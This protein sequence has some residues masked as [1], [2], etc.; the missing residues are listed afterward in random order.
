LRASGLS[1]KFTDI[2]KESECDD[3]P[4]S[5]SE[6]IQ[7]LKQSEKLFCQLN[8]ISHYDSPRKLQDE[9]SCS[10]LKEKVE[11]QN[12]IRQVSVDLQKFKLGMMKTARGTAQVQ[13]FVANI[14]P[15]QDK[16]FDLLSLDR[17][18]IGISPR[19]HA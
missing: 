8:T 9:I 5:I 2:T 15:L 1:K 17:G 13:Q 16:I 10:M 6:L 3:L 12:K 18:I 7:R 4:N 19:R 11:I 14:K